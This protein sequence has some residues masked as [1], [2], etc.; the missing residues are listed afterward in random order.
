MNTDIETE[1][2]FYTLPLDDTLL[3]LNPEE[4]AFFKSQTR[5]QDT[6]ELRKHIVRVQKD[7]YKVIR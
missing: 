3:E 2:P 4:E 7:A 1:I 6:D 5:I